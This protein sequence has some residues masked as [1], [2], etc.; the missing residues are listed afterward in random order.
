MEEQEKNNRIDLKERKKKETGRS[1]PN[2]ENIRSQETRK[3]IYMEQTKQE[4]MELK[5]A[6]E[7]LWKHMRTQKQTQTNQKSQEDQRSCFIFSNR[8]N[9][10]LSS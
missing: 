3:E 2:K 1:W 6:K 8:A 9:F 7:S 5:A 10:G 4:R